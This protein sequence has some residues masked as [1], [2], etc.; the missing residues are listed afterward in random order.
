MFGFR[1]TAFK[2]AIGQP[3]GDVLWARGYTSLEFREVQV[4]DINVGVISILCKIIE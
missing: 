1:H 4:G 2:M 3:K